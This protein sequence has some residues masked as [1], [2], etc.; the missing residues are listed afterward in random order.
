MKKYSTQQ[1]STH[2]VV[3]VCLALALL[4]ALGWIFYQNFIYKETPKKD[5]DLVVVEKDNEGDSDDSA[6]LEKVTTSDYTFEL[7]KR[8]SKV[9]EQQFTTTA[10][11][12]AEASYLDQETGDYF[13][14]LKP[15]GAGGG[16]SADAFWSY[17]I[18]GGGAIVVEDRSLEQCKS[19]DFGCTN[20]NGSTEAIVTPNESIKSESSY[21]LAFGNT[22]REDVSKLD[23]IN[24]I[25]D[26]FSFK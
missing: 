24:D 7:P 23:F 13:E 18:G 26:S 19:G 2:A 10:S 5:T 15:A 12:K 16:M 9:S 3:V 20:G 4:T 1:G 8:F 21:Y 25:L 22:K 17:S 11:L 6:K 14:V